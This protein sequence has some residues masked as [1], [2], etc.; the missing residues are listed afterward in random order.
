MVLISKKDTSVIISCSTAENFLKDESNRIFLEECGVEYGSIKEEKKNKK[1]TIKTDDDNS[2]DQLVYELKEQFGTELENDQS[3]K[4]IYE[5][6]EITEKKYQEYKKLGEVI[7]RK[8][9]I[10]NKLF[11]AKKGFKLKPYQEKSVSHLVSIPNTAN[12]SIPGAGKTL[13]TYA[14]FYIL[15]QKKQIDQMIVVGPRASFGPWK[16]ELKTFT[17]KGWQENLIQYHGSIRKRNKIRKKFVGVDI[18]ITTYDTAAND[19]IQLRQYIKSS[20]KKILLVLDE[21]HKI[22]NI[23]EKTETENITRSENMI[24]LGEAVSRRCILSGTPL[25][26]E[27]DDLWSQITFLWP[28][29]KPFGN[30]LEFMDMIERLGV[31]KRISKEVQRRMD[32]LWTRVSARN[33]KKDLPK[34]K[35]FLRKVAM[36]EIQEEIYSIIRSKLTKSLKGRTANF[37]R[38]M[39]RAR[40]VRLLQVVTNPRLIVEKD[41]VYSSQAP[42]IQAK[43]RE[44]VKVLK[45]IQRYHKNQISNKIREVAELARKLSNEKKNVVIFTHFRGNVKLLGKILADKKPLRIT[46][47]IT[48]QEDQENIIEEFKNWN[49]KDGKGK[50]LIATAG[51]VAESVSLHKNKDNKP[52]CNNAIFL[53]RSYDAGKYMQALYRTYRIGSLKSRPV[54]YYIFESVYADSSNTIDATIADVLT[55]RVQRLQELVEDELKLNVVSLDTAKIGGEEQ[56]YTEGMNEDEIM[57][58]IEKEEIQ[59]MRS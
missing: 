49:F 2:A 35:F 54:N 48:K 13:M 45:L 9:R 21:S 7:K 14:G 31:D 38:K 26:H 47:Q 39:R 23:H 58:E 40:I 36:D 10:K 56:F 18:I 37:V 20:G 32:F 15:K 27:W 51:T 52:V 46:G 11:N 57:K 43:S 3:I 16:N 33:L 44:N 12:F 6:K 22:K 17:G 8:K 28:K 53:E 34:Q 25:P 24:R 19:L 59:N 55:T 29:M 50:I 30:R 5:Q 42:M 41:P 1:F 4:K